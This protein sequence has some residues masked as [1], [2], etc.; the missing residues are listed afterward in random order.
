MNNKIPEIKNSL[1]G[2]AIRLD[3]AEDRISKLEDKVGGKKNTQKE[4]EKKKRL[5]KNEQVVRELQDNMKQNNIHIIE[6]PEGEESEQ[7]IE[8]LFEKVMME[9]ILI[10]REKKS[11]KS[12]KYRESHSS[13][14]EPI[15]R[16]II[17]KMANI[18]D[19]ERILKTA[20]GNKKLH[21]R[22]P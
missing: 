19:K 10:S 21:T 20:R 6:I 12:R 9:N 5:R 4:Q 2:I 11:P 13:G 16:D 15:S 7:W 14:K 18:Q 17:I 3:V 8:N 1:E 22:Q